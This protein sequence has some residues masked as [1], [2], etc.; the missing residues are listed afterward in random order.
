MKDPSPIAGL[1]AQPSVNNAKTS[2]TG[3]RRAVLAIV[4]CIAACEGESRPSPVSVTAPPLPG[5][6]AEVLERKPLPFCG[7]EQISVSETGHNVQGRQCF[8]SAYQAGL[9]A[10][11]ISQRRTVEGDPITELFRLLP[12]GGIELFIDSRED[13]FSTRKWLR[14]ECS[15]LTLLPDAPGQPS[16][17]VDDCVEVTMSTQ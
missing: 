15:S 5:A 7:E 1:R 4:V 13:R 12:E 8:W 2:M 9:P 10:E 6:P 16:F 11:F 14:V 3:W 17:A